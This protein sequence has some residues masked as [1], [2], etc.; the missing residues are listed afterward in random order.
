[1]DRKTGLVF[2]C[3]LI[4]PLFSISALTLDGQ[5]FSEGDTPVPNSTVVLLELDLITITEFDGSFSFQDVSEDE[6]SLL[7]IA[8]GFEEM[9]FIVTASADPL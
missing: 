9:V 4:I 3:M 5:V 6:Y 2:F 7:V 8:P 1:M